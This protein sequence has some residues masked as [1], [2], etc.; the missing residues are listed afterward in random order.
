[1]E[2]LAKQGEVGSSGKGTAV[3]P[4]AEALR[5]LQQSPKE[6]KETVQPLFP[7]TLGDLNTEDAPHLT[8]CDPG[9]W[10]AEPQETEFWQKVKASERVWGARKWG[11][12]LLSSERNFLK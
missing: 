7:V 9:R 1:M 10:A 4:S 5:N 6:R 12:V 8:H 2:F 3:I 11:Q